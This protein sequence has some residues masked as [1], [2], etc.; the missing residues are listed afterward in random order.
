[1]TISAQFYNF[2]DII[3]ITVV[4]YYKYM[5]HIAGSYTPSTHSIQLSQHT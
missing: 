1:M 5:N 3:D 2:I 4:M